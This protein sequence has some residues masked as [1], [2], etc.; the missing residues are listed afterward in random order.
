MWLMP[1]WM[2][3]Y[4]GPGPA[5]GEALRCARLRAEKASTVCQHELAETGLCIDLVWMSS[6]DG[7]MRDGQLRAWLHAE[8][9]RT[10]S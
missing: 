10:V 9:A 4:W 3:F 5:L 8:S 7:G 2:N 1:C 6:Y